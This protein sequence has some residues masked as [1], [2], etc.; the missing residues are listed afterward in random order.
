MLDTISGVAL[1]GV[2]AA[3]FALLGYQVYRG[4]GRRLQAEGA[5][6]AFLLFERELRRA[7]PSLPEGFTWRE[8]VGEAK[9][10]GVAADW[11]EVGME[12]DAF[13]AYRYGGRQ[14]PTAF[15]GVLALARE[16]RGIR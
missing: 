4:R 1:A 7:I 11:P 12:V 15:G 9:K 16:L 3:I 14:E 8:A 13:E 6:Q 5:A 10:L 2:D